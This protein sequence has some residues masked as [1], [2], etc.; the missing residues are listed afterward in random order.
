MPTAAQNWVLD[1]SG[2]WELQTIQGS[3]SHTA[4]FNRTNEIAS[5]NGSSS[6]ASYDDPGNMTA[7]DNGTWQ[8]RFT[9]WNQIADILG[10]GG[11]INLGHFEYDGFGRRI[12]KTRYY[13][14]DGREYYYGGSWQVLEETGQTYPTLGK[15]YVWGT[16]YIDELVW[17]SSGHYSLQDANFNV[18]TKVLASSGAVSSRF[19][20]TPYGV[21]T[22]YDA[23]YGYIL[24]ISDDAPLFTGREYQ[25]EAG[26]YD[27]R[28]RFYDPGLGKFLA[29]DAL[30]TWGDEA[31]VGNAYQYVAAN[32]VGTTD[33]LGLVQVEI[34]ANSFIPQGVVQVHSWLTVFGPAAV[35]IQGDKR[36]AGQ[37]GSSRTAASAVVELDCLQEMDPLVFKDYVHSVSKWQ[38]IQTLLVGSEVLVLR[39]YHS[40]KGDSTWSIE[41]KRIDCCT[42]EVKVDVSAN[43][44]D[45]LWFHIAGP[46]FVFQ[47]DIDYH[48]TM[49]L[50]QTSSGVKYK[51]TGYHDGFPGFELMLNGALAYSWDPRGHGQTGASQFGNGEWTIDPPI[52]DTV[53]PVGR[54]CTC[55][56]NSY[57]EQGGGTSSLVR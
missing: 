30:G 13:W 32:P 34:E 37:R 5:R 33:P 48:F 49:L 12:H 44:A 25:A 52:E 2:N 28:S 26:V 35:A 3:P 1:R 41:A 38:F 4:T 45:L 36:R 23:N 19:V 24:S 9:A 54:D 51:V 16:N 8:Y 57:W 20:Y 50:R 55:D 56:E 6:Y 10:Y 15:Q 27:Y 11:S 39:T 31:N 29:R 17:M 53:E 22:Q 7:K 18:T 47:P 40:G 14:S 43:A 21:P 42:A 46:G